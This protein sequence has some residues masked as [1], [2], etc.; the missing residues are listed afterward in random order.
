MGDFAKHVGARAD[1]RV[2][3]DLTSQIVGS[4]LHLTFTRIAVGA[5][6]AF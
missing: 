3:R 5:Y 4:P 6:I 1:V 2:F